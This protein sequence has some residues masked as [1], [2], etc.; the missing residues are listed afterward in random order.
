MKRK[1]GSRRAGRRPQLIL[2]HLSYSFKGYR[3]IHES[4]RIKKTL[5]SEHTTSVPLLKKYQHMLTTK[6]SQKSGILER[7]PIKPILKNFRA[8]NKRLIPFNGPYH[9][10]DINNDDISHLST[11]PASFAIKSNVYF[12]THQYLI[13]NNSQSQRALS[14]SVRT[15]LRIYFASR[16]NCGLTI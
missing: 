1:S 13:I 11:I 3:K 10:L 9:P 15:V 12:L 4:R 14:V 6:I 16:R 5:F 2:I 7:T 8:E